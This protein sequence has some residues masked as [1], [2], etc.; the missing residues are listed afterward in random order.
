MFAVRGGRDANS[1]EYTAGGWYVGADDSVG[2]HRKCRCHRQGGQ[3]RP[4]LQDDP[5]VS[6]AANSP[7]TQGGQGL[8][9]RGTK[10]ETAFAVSFFII[11]RRQSIVK[12]GVAIFQT[13]IID[14]SLAADEFGADAGGQQNGLADVVLLQ[15]D[16]NGHLLQMHTDQR[17]ADVK[18]SVG[19]NLLQR[20]G[21]AEILIGGGGKGAASL[22]L[23]H[24]VDDLAIG[25]GFVLHDE[26]AVQVLT[27]LSGDIDPHGS[28]HAVQP[29][30]DGSCTPYR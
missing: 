29:L 15:A 6:L 4:P 12:Y 18:A 7:F 14:G 13:F 11:F 21:M 3:G 22:G 8:A 23:R 27:A 26:G 1:Y 17:T 20:H 2:P 25:D 24:H 9:K 28:K 5:Q 19:T 16:G 30:K 10:N